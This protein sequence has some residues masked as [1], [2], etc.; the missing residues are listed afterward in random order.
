MGSLGAHEDIFNK[1]VK[2]EWEG[3]LPKGVFNSFSEWCSR[4]KGIEELVVRFTFSNPE[5]SSKYAI[6]ILCHP[7]LDE[8]VI[9]RGY[10]S[11]RERPLAML[12]SLYD[13]PLFCMPSNLLDRILEERGMGD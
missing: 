5:D 9:I 10:K 13:K 4:Q 2:G 1:I 7:S 12:P 6:Y 8:K 3:V 11:Q